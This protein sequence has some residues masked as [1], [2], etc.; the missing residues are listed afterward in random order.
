MENKRLRCSSCLAISGLGSHA[1]G[2]W[3][4]RRSSYMWLR[5]A[6]PQYLPNARVLIY[7][8]DSK[9]AGSYS[10]QN[11]SDV[12]SRLRASLRVAL[13]PV[14]RDRPL[15]FIAHSLGGLVLKQAMVQMSSGDAADSRNFKATYGILFFGVPSQGMYIS[16]LLAMVRGQPNLHFLST[17]SKDG[18]FLQG[19]IEQFRAVFVFPDSRIYSFYETEMSPTAQEGDPGKWSMNGRPA[20]LVDRYSARSGRSWEGEQFHMPISSKHSEMVKFSEYSEDFGI[21]C[22]ILRH[23]VQDAPPVI[24]QRW[25]WW[26]RASAAEISFSG[27]PIFNMLFS[28]T[29][30]MPP[31][32]KA[33]STGSGV[34]PNATESADT[35]FNRRPS[36]STTSKP[37]LSGSEIM[38]TIQKDNN[39]ESDTHLEVAT[40]NRKDILDLPNAIG[41]E[42]P[43]KGSL[44]QARV[45][46]NKT[47]RFSEGY[48]RVGVVPDLGNGDSMQTGRCE[49]LQRQIY[50]S[51]T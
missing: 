19:L 40:T 38:P 47:V 4:D 29:S 43:S 5:D 11:L 28:D 6:L 16:S 7:G 39:L 3:K 24:S 8:Y 14:S 9:L 25:W 1:F 34:Q 23:F 50:I 20:V 10:F 13:G 46:F 42:S 30:T 44:E 51:Y 17:L 32:S 37:D 41:N 33:Q 2:S 12:G 45:L 49:H 31:T 21:V 22:D 48:T 15:I 36:S 26:E 18:G 27:K 35:K